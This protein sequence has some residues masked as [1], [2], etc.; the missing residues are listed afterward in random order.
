MCAERTVSSTMLPSAN[1]TDTNY[2]HSRSIVNTVRF[3]EGFKQIIWSLC[4]I[5]SWPNHPTL[6]YIYESRRVNDNFRGAIVFH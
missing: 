6:L 1:G 3:I 2:T 4:V 5:I